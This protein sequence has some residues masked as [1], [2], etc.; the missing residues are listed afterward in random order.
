MSKSLSITTCIHLPDAYATFTHTFFPG[1][2]IL[3]L[4]GPLTDQTERPKQRSRGAGARYKSLWSRGGVQLGASLIGSGLI[5]QLQCVRVFL[6]SFSEPER[7]ERPGQ[8]GLSVC[9]SLLLLVCGFLSFWTPIRRVQLCS[10][11][12]RSPRRRGAVES[13]MCDMWDSFIFSSL[14][15][16]TDNT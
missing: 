13:R 16:H 2:I 11:R 1:A 8:S 10:A 4:C 7:C 12:S 3:Q 5:T 14:I 15:F 6:S 9:L